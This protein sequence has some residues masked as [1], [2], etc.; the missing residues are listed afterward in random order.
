[1][2]ALDF[3][4]IDAAG[5]ALMLVFQPER[6]IFM[7]FGVAVGLIIGLIPGIGGLTG[8]ALLIP[9][10]YTMDPIA[11][12]GML[13]G[14]QAVTTTSDTLPAVLIGVPGTSSAQAL[15]LDGHEL[16]KKGEAARALAAGYTSSLMGGVFGAFLLAFTIPFIRPFV[17]AIGTPELFAITTLALAMVAAL[18]GNAPLRGVAIACFGILISMI[19]IDAQTAQRRWTGSF[20]YL[21]DGVPIMPLMLG[22]FALPELCELAIARKPLA[23]NVKFDPKKGRSQGIRDALTHWFLVVRSSILGV[24]CGAIPGFSGAVVDWMAY[25]HAARTEK[26]ASE[27][28]T[29]GDIRGVI[30]PEAAANAINSGSL[31]TTLVFGVP[32]S[33]AMAILIGAMLVH[34][35]VPGP[36]MMTTHL[37]ITYSMVWS[38]MVAN[39][40]GTLAC[41]TLSVY[42]ARI[43][44]LRYTLL[45]PAILVVV[46][47]GAYQ[48]SS[49]WG[50]M[51]VLLVAGLV[52]WAMKRLN[53]PRP[54]LVLGLVLGVLLERYLG[55]SIVRYGA[56]WLYRPGVMG[57][58]AIAV[59]VLA[60]PLINE[61]RHGGLSALVPSGRPVFKLSDLFYVIL[62][63]ITVLMMFEASKWPT[64]A[65]LGPQI[66]GTV[67]L[68]GAA[69]SFYHAVTA[70]GRP[71]EDERDI[72][73]RGIYMDIGSEKDD[74]GNRLVLSRAAQFFGWFL[75]FMGLMAVIGLIPTIPVFVIAY[76]RFHA[77][78][79]WR[80]TVLYAAGVTL[81]VYVVFDQLI[82]VFWP[83]TVLGA[84][85]PQLTSMIPSV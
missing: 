39:I 53:W 44:T 5:S 38:M 1:M 78:E 77:R 6:M 82:R 76:L 19:G 50:D 84:L 52:G 45:L 74:L 67:L 57:V 54:P 85:F 60:R 75:L 55:I 68:I 80:L 81:F 62:M 16:A 8:F 29:K 22:L 13:L 34:G 58:L 2:E 24:V 4:V 26:G 56:D 59:L 7:V 63:G 41:I 47:I 25:G 36:D 71:I 43:A 21:W 40:I 65:R 32:G 33:A 9:F 14:M 35:I 42:F 17:L 79:P 64:A 3:S 48:A 69:V 73:Y 72:S 70:R 37:D 12:L 46:Y 27:T 23:D 61:I 31:G 20:V 15:V 11:A 83:N 66:V 18:S 10:T 28:F 30:A 49:S 51:L